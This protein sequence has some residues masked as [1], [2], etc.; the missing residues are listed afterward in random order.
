MHDCLKIQEIV[1]NIFQHISQHLGSPELCYWPRLG[2]STLAGLARTCKVFA[3]PVLDNLW[4]YQTSLVP[5]ILCLPPDAI[6]IETKEPY[7]TL[8]VRLPAF[9]TLVFSFLSWS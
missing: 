7:N 4:Y 2:S 1:T 5:L 6:K 9:L 3:E 8:M